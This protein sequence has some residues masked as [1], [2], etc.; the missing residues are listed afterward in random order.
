MADLIKKIKI[1]KQ[2]GT[3][4]DYIPIGAN[5]VNIETSDGESVEL[6]LNKKPYYYNT[7][8]DMKAD[9][10]LKAG[11]TV[12]T[13]G[14]YSANDGGAGLYK[15]VEDNTLVDDGGSIHELEN[16]LKAELI[17][18]DTITPEQFG[19]YGDGIHDD[20][21]AIQAVINNFNNILFL[22]KTYLLES[23]IIINNISSLNIMGINNNSKIKIN[24]NIYAFEFKS[25]KDKTIE[26]LFFDINNGGGILKTNNSELD[27]DLTIRNINGEI[28]T[29]NNEIIKI[30]NMHHLKIENCYLVNR[31][32]SYNPTAL[33]LDG[34]VNGTIHKNN[35]S[36]FEKGIYITNNSGFTNEGIIINENLFYQNKNQ[37]IS[38]NTNSIL[39]YDIN[40]NIFDY[41]ETYGIK[42]QNVESSIIS[43]NYFG[44]NNENCICVYIRQI[45]NVH[46]DLSI[47]ENKFINYL[48]T[49][50]NPFIKINDIGDKIQNGLKIIENSATGFKTFVD[51]NEINYGSVLNNTSQT[52][53]S[54]NDFITG[55]SISNINYNN[56]Q[57][58]G[59][60]KYIH[61]I[62]NKNRN[63][64]G[65][66]TDVKSDISHNVAY[67]PANS[68]GF[69]LYITFANTSQET[70]LINLMLSKTGN[71]SLIIGNQSIA[72]NAIYENFS[73]F[74]P[75]GYMFKY[76]AANPS[77][78][79]I[80][81]AHAIY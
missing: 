29:S 33:N 66:Y 74:V 34:V 45:N 44:I 75:A 40:N 6:K 73:I 21:S 58:G 27:F 50:N 9:T 16:G 69:Y 51:L 18:E 47:N 24:S 42:L 71:D 1:K 25:L 64:Y 49:M 61:S 78:V 65:E 68:N 70:Q 12:Q 60:P 20:S 14:Y 77:S 81:N 2:D 62:L 30:V 11:D 19:A 55:N 31:S 3:F 72:A 15:I 26:N 46:T 67:K 39:F 80:Q 53:I 43:N 38:N 13:L 54:P 28:R 32:S 48:Q 23:P 57:N 37:I 35:F 41:C 36:H 7:I 59:G 56:N 76:N 5:A 17:V 10:K 79:I 63:I 8:A 22:E 4:T 52:S